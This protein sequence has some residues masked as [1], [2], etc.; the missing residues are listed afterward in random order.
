MSKRIRSITTLTVFIIA[1]F[2]L[3]ACGSSDQSKSSYA[4]IEP[5]EQSFTISDF[6]SVGF[7][8]VKVYDVEGLTGASKA[9]HG[10]QKISGGTRLSYELRFYNSHDD[11]VNLGTSFAVEITGEDAIMVTDDMTWSGGN[12]QQREQLVEGGG[13]QAFYWGYKIFGNIVML[14]EGDWVEQSQE[15]CDQL[16]ESISPTTTS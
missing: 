3:T 5:S 6:E 8:V 12:K 13:Y 4:Q 14:C 1:A 11:A 2:V 16:K 10:F 15:A 9:V 7:K